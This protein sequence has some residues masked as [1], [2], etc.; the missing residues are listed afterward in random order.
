[1]GVIALDRARSRPGDATAVRYRGDAC[2]SRSS[3]SKGRAPQLY[4]LRRRDHADRNWDDLLREWARIR[5]Q[6]R[7]IVLAFPVDQM[8][9]RPPS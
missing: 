1:M 3:R 2:R 9:G 6:L 5:D 7:G 8:Q 4:E